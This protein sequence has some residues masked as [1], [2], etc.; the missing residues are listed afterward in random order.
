MR[1]AQPVS[2]FWQIIIIILSPIYT[3]GYIYNTETCNNVLRLHRKSFTT[4]KNMKE[5]PSHLLIRAKHHLM[6]LFR[7]AQ[8]LNKNTPKTCFWPE[9]HGLFQREYQPWAATYVQL[10]RIIAKLLR[11][12]AKSIIYTTLF[13]RI[14]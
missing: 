13:F 1:T 6:Q 10:L 11:I 5:M 3:K 8:L 7:C 4:L 2:V 12:V 14:K 9:P